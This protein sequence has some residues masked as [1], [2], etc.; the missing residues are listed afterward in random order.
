MV[1]PHCPVTLG[2]AMGLRLTKESPR[3][4]PAAGFSEEVTYITKAAC[5]C[6]KSEG[7]VES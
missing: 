3:L 2:L 7:V 6:M 4:L 1:T 5:A